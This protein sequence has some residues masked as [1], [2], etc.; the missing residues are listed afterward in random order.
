MLTR[1]DRYWDLPYNN[2]NYSYVDVAVDQYKYNTF[3]IDRLGIGL[4]SHGEPLN[5]IQAPLEVAALAELT[6]QLRSG[7]LPGVPTA[8]KRVVHVGRVFPESQTPAHAANFSPRHSF[9]SAQTYALVN[10]YPSI[11]DAIV[12]TGFSLNSSFLPLFAVGAD[13]VL[14]NTNQPFRLGNV[15]TNV[16]ASVLS[17]NTLNNI[18]TGA[19]ASLIETYGLTDYFA[20]LQPPPIQPLNY[21]NGYLTNS[22]A[23]SAQYLFLLPKFFDPA[24]GLFGESTKQ[25]VTLGELLTL[26]CV[27]KTNAYAG[28]VFVLT[29]CK[30]P[31]SHATFP[32]TIF[33]RF[34]LDKILLTSFYFNS[35]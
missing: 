18:T 16:A 28:P 33:L 25:P 24:I 9:G 22:N 21:P 17:A 12:L 27:P 35:A 6:L 23:N 15:G 31:L 1:H 34:L 20:G 30:S 32:P 3:A 2:F 8:F 11:S 13:F 5:E 14:A 29:G 19:A 7:S 26:S 10:Q 4:S